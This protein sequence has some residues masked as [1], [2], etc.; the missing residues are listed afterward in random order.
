MRY[1][2]ELNLLDY[3]HADTPEAMYLACLDLLEQATLSCVTTANLI[4]FRPQ[5]PGTNDGPRVWN[6]QLIRYSGYRQPDGSILGEKVEADF[7]TMLQEEFGWVPP[8]EEERTRFDVLPVLL[9]AHPDQEPKAFEL[10]PQYVARV[11]IT[12]PE[13]PGFADLGLQWYPVPAVSCLELSVGGLTY[14]A[15]PFNGWYAV[16]EIVRNLTEEGRY[17]Q[18]PQVAALLGLDTRADGNMWRDQAIVT[19]TQAVMHSFRTASYGMVDHHTLM[20]NFWGWYNQEKERRGYVPGNWKWIIPPVSPTASRC[21]LELAH[22]TEYTIKPNYW[23]APMWRSYLKRLKENRAKAAALAG[24]GGGPADPKPAAVEGAAAA[25]ARAAADGAEAGDSKLARVFIAYASVTGTTAKYAQSIAGV[26]S[27]PLSVKVMDMEDFEPDSWR[28]HIKAATLVVLALSTYGPGAPPSTAGKFMA[29]LQ[30]GLAIGG[31]A[32]EALHGKPF[33]VLGFGCTSYPRFCAAADSLYSLV[34]A[35]GATPVVPTGKVDSLSHEEATVWAWTRELLGAARLRALVA[36]GALEDAAG[37][38]PMSTDGKPKP[39]VPHFTLIDLS[40]VEN[41]RA[42][43]DRFRQDARMVEVRELLRGESGAR[44]A[45]AATKQVI[46]DVRKVNGGGLSYLAGDELAVWG[47]NPAD[48]VETVA[49]ALGLG[50]GRLDSMFLLQRAEAAAADAQDG[51]DAAA[52]EAAT[53]A[54]AAGGGGGTDAS[55]LSCAPFPLPNTYRTILT[56][57]VALCDAPSWEAVRAL[58]LYAPQDERL[59]GYAESYTAYQ[60]WVTGAGVRW[61]DVW[62]EFPA[63]AG[64]LPVEVFLQLVPVVKPRHYSISSSAAHHPGQLHLTISRLAYKLASGETRLGFCSSFLAS[65]APGDRVSVK[66]LPTPGFRMPLDPA[67]PVIMVAAGTGLAPFKS[68]WEE[69]LARA[70]K[71]KARAGSAAAVSAAGVQQ[72][73]PGVLIFGCRN[74]TED[75]IYCDT[76]EE[77]VA[78]GALSKVLTAF[79]RDPAQRKQ[80]V[81]DVVTSHA[82]ELAPLLRNKACHV[83]VCGSSNMATEVAVAFRKVLGADEYGALVQ[84]GRY[85]EDVFGMVVPDHRAARKAAAAK[86]AITLLGSASAAEVAELLDGGGLALDAVDHN[87]ASL[88]HVAVRARNTPLVEL[89]LDRGC[90]INVLDVYGCTPLQV[91]RMTAQPALAELIEARGGKLAS[92]L[93]SQY[94][95]V[96]KAVMEGDVEGL[97]KLIARGANLAAVEYHGLTPLHVA[98]AVASPEVIQIL[99]DAKAPFDATTR[100]GLLPLQLALVLQRSD[101]AEQLKA[102]G[103]PLMVK[104]VVTADA[105]GGAGGGSAGVVWNPSSTDSLSDA[106]GIT[107]QEMAALQG[108]WEAMSGSAFPEETRKIVEDFGVTFFLSLFEQCPHLLA[109]FPFKDDQGKPITAELRVHGA[110]VLSM[111]GWTVQMFSNYPLLIRNTEDLVERHIAYG[112]E[113]AHYHLLFGVLSSVLEQT[114]GDVWTATTDSAWRKVGKLVC[115]VAEVVYGRQQK[116]KQPQQQE[117]EEPKGQSS[118][119]GKEAQ[120]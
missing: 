38:I 102:A 81:Q 87:S 4:A 1:V 62:K 98:C 119:A 13:Q 24:N 90:G 17:D 20:R 75:F 110:K 33:A 92:L 10:P 85:H 118:P 44:P 57:Y 80:Y 43:R 28:E 65:R 32:H 116:D 35:T 95:P 51:D 36:G 64:R 25:T 26:L 89:L 42:A 88:L 68:F 79:S 15:C 111:L 78:Q 5:T 16:T 99:I 84:A 2:Q 77:A 105:G 22:M 60:S 12:H 30:K 3:R 86:G 54:A 50:G 94:Y 91:A 8:P 106:V 19:V 96:H 97:K 76:I 114:L 59:K 120:A 49:T 6:T 69:R 104:Q 101:A 29:W 112:V 66:V 115:G 14:T 73:G 113:L 52:A 83:Y 74:S 47:E 21:Y 40:G 11:D 48:A 9:Q 7:T 103:A 100:R 108:S 39:F 93:V 55:G 63:L 27:G 31:E 46:F 34:C 58:A 61:S 18:C 107:E 72:P 37:G 82:A 71:A 41:I 56:S 53:A 117:G 45:G 67:S 109:L 23:Y 70:A